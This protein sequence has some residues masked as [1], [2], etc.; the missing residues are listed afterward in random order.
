MLDQDIWSKDTGKAII[1]RIESQ[2]KSDKTLTQEATILLH[3]GG[4][5]LQMDSEKFAQTIQD[6]E[7]AYTNAYSG[8]AQQPFGQSLEMQSILQKQ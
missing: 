4:D 1:D 3:G 5:I 7:D 2:L 8:N 6:I